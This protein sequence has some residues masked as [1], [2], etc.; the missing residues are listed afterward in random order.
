MQTRYLQNKNKETKLGFVM[1]K[2]STEDNSKNLHINEPIMSVRIN[3]KVYSCET[4]A[5]P[6]ELAS[7]I[8]RHANKRHAS[9]PT[10]KSI[11]SIIELAKL[12]QE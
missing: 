6:T 1:I 3:N 7:S 2:T 9:F 10:Q 8:R 5:L 12:R 4:D 11:T